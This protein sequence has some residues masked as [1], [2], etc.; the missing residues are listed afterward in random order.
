M[1]AQGVVDCRA[2]DDAS[3]DGIDSEVDV[4]AFELADFGHE[5]FGGDAAETDLVI[6]ANL[7]AIAGRAVLGL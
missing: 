3:S 2:L 6:N 5:I 4:L 1:S 7:D